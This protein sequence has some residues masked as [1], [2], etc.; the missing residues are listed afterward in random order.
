MEAPRPPARHKVAANQSKSQPTKKPANEASER[1]PSP[2]L[3]NLCRVSKWLSLA[4]G[5]CRAH[6]DRIAAL[7]NFIRCVLLWLKF[8]FRL[9]FLIWDSLSKTAAIVWFSLQVSKW[10]AHSVVTH[11]YYTTKRTHTKHR[12]FWASAQ[13]LFFS[14]HSGSKRNYLSEWW[15]DQPASINCQLQSIAFKGTP[16][17]RRLLL[18]YTHNGTHKVNTLLRKREPAK[19]SSQFDSNRAELS[20]KETKN[21]ADSH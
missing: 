11:S 7:S 20:Q 10:G 3:C 4:V 16:L 13:K 21:T 1:A 15:D 6:R 14:Y 18:F 9:K 19:L 12:D 17:S 8:P 2:L 5:C